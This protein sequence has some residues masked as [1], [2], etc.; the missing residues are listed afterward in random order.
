[1]LSDARQVGSRLGL[2][3]G[4]TAWLAMLEQVIPAE[5]LS[6]PAGA[7][8]RA[9]LTRTRVQPID[10]DEI[11]AAVPT[12]ESQ[13]DVW[14][15][16][17]HVGPAL[18]GGI[19]SGTPMPSLPYRLGPVARYFYVYAIVSVIPRLLNLNRARGI[20]DEITWTTLGDLGEKI[21]VHRRM[22]GVGGLDR[23]HWLG[24]QCR[25]DLHQLG[26]L[27]FE[28]TT[29]GQRAGTGPAWRVGDPAIGVH[30]PE[31]GGPLSSRACDDAFTEMRRFFGRHYP[32]HPATIATCASWL[33]DPQLVEYLSASSNIPAFQGRFDVPHDQPATNPADAAVLDFVFRRPPHVDLDA[34]P[35]DTSLRRAVVAHLRDGRH[36]YAPTGVMII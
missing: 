15:L 25:G 2:D 18:G 33:L 21:G 24:R 22:R 5:R 32:D 17:R 16:L 27:Q 23:Q 12:A 14:W 9:V 26:R 13:P 3:D 11:V 10:A 1:M 35:Q 6:L 4:Y 7:E 34:L 36:W 31:S 28:V 29:I 19:D 8:L 20:D 30:I